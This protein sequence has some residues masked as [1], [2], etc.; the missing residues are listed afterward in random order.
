[1]QSPRWPKTVVASMREAGIEAA[2]LD[3][4]C[5]YEKPAAHFARIIETHLAA[6][7]GVTLPVLVLTARDAVPDSALTGLDR[8]ILGEFANLE[9]QVAA[10]YESQSAAARER[11]D[12]MNVL[13]GVS[14]GLAAASVAG[15][16]T[17][18]LAG[19]AR[20][21]ASPL[22]HGFALGAAGSF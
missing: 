4:V 2:A 18:L 14:V 5:F 13:F 1:M 20:V 22:A 21:T 8:W 15:G 16:V 12:A 17:W 9:Q 19:R 6:L 3:H 7:A 11:F 10:A